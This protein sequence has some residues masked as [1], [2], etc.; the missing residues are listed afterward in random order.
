MAEESILRR[1]VISNATV[2]ALIGSRFYEGELATISRPKYP[3]ANFVFQ[4]G[5]TDPDFSCI[6]TRTLKIWAWSKDAYDITRAI[7]SAIKA[8]IDNESFIDADCSVVFKQTGEPVDYY[9]AVAKV[10][11]TTGLFRVRRI[12]K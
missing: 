1:N 2:A 5:S 7:Y 11:C 6:G 9:D 10:D 3:C 4:S 12:L 8:V